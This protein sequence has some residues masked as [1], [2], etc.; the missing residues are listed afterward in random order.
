MFA[1]RAL[2]L[3]AFFCLC[4]VDPA[5]SQA[6]PG[7]TIVLPPRLLTAQ[8]ATLAVLDT[9]GRLVPS[10]VVEFSGG[11]RVTTDSTGRALFT[12]PSDPGILLARLPGRLGRASATVG[13]PTPSPPDGVQ[14][15]DYPAVITLDDRFVVEGAGFHGNANSVQV[16][17]ANQPALVLASS[18]LS[19]VLLPHPGLKPGPAQLVIEVAGRSPGPVPLTLVSL[20]LLPLE[21]ALKP[22]EK[23]VLRVRVRGTDQRLPIEA[24]NLTPETI[25]FQRGDILRVTSS[26]GAVN[27]AL[28]EIQALKAGDFSVTA[29]LIPGVSGLPDVESARQKLIAARQLAPEEWLDRINR[30]IRR[31][32]RDPQ[33]ALKVRD[34]LEKMLAENPPG[35]FGSRLEAAWRA[36]LN[37]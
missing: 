29:R 2:F 10:A 26:G 18:P 31:I 25:S 15:L 9:A 14:V 27:D 35:E 3:F 20:N 30:L 4:V 8:Q 33:D 7:T 17:L 1:A 6:G 11:E 16:M 23:G 5:Y 36:L 32:E 19:L 22:G 13:A 37:R 34:E 28:L 24:R 21:N 12:A